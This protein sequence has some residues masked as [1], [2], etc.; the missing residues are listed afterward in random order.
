MLYKCSNLSPQRHL[1]P[2]PGSTP[3]QAPHSKS[4]HSILSEAKHYAGCSKWQQQGH[5]Q[6]QLLT[7]QHL[8]Q[9][10]VHPLARLVAG[11]DEHLGLTIT[12][13]V[14]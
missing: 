14:G 12:R 6:Q 2:F 8:C 11:G 13:E 5:L 3:R 4:P 7:H 1:K 10:G 9:E